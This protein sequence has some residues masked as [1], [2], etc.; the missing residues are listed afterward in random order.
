MLGVNVLSWSMNT[1][2]LNKYKRY[3]R[4]SGGKH[5]VT[6][7][8]LYKGS[9]VSIGHNQYLKTHPKQKAYAEAVG[10]SDRQYLH[11]EIDC[12]I[13]ARKPIDTLIVVRYNAVGNAVNAKPCKI[14][15]LAIQQAGIKKVIHS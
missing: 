12:L 15:Q 11:A 3:V 7:I 13:R 9:I 1:N 10:E 6:A 8:G 14:C 2:P 4:P 5:S